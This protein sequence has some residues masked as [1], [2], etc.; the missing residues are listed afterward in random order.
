FRFPKLGE[1]E[2]GGLALE[3]RQALEPWLVLGGTSGPG[4][5]SLP[6]DSA[7]EGVRGLERWLVLGETSGPGGTSRPV[8]SSLE[9]VQVLVGGGSGDRYAVA[10]NGYR[11]PL[12]GTGASGQAIAGARFRS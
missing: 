5:T 7:V 6:A 10:C 11:L 3:L 8:D 1:I 9:R 2:R 12:A 4:G